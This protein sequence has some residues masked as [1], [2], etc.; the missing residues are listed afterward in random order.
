MHIKSYI[1]D[2]IDFLDKI[3]MDINSSQCIPIDNKLG[4]EPITYWAFKY[5]SLL[6]QSISKD[7]IINAVTIVLECNTVNLIW[8][9]T[10]KYQEQQW[11]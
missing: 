4:V 8:I 1:R 3:Q 7:L 10:C 11:A 2:D 9:I 5:P 6:P